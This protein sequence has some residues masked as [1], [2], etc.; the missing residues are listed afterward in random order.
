MPARPIRKSWRSQFLDLCQA[1]KFTEATA[2]FDS[3]MKEVLGPAKLEEL[4]KKLG[5]QLGPIAKMGPARTD[6]VGSS[7]RA[8][9]RCDFKTMPLDAL[10]SF[11]PQGQIEGFF[12]VPA[13]KTA[14]TPDPPYV[15]RSKFTEEPITVGARRLAFAWNADTT[16]WRRLR[17]AGDPGARLRPQ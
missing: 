12:L 4:W 11:N 6:R 8:K 7:T 13:E 10:V 3:K 2:H 1:G 17:T 14:E 5:Q 15:D 16:E 9:I